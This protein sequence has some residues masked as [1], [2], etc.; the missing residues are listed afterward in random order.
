MNWEMLLLT[1]GNIFFWQIKDCIIV[2][3]SKKYAKSEH[4]AIDILKEI[5]RG[6][7]RASLE[8]VSKNMHVKYY[9]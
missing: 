3:Y 2:P 9:F 7:K 8:K 6:D 5:V 1:I 4:T